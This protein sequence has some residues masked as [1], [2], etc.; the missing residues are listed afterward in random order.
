VHGIGNTDR[1]NADAV[2]VR[3]MGPPITKATIGV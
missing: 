2:W 3:V 1:V